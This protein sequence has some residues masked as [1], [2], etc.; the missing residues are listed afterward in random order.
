MRGM[1]RMPERLKELPA[2]FYLSPE[3]RNDTRGL[4]ET[5]FSEDSRK[6][7]DF[8]YTYK[9]RDNEILALEQDGQIVSMLHLNPYRMIVN[10]YET[11][12]NYIVAVATRE[13][14]RHR[15]CMRMLLKKAL[16]DMAAQGM[17]FAFL[18]PASERIY[19][20]F[21]FVWIGAYTE[22]PERVRRMDADD[23]NRYLAARYQ[24]FCK[25][26]ARYM[27]N[28]QAE[29]AA[30][31][32]ETWDGA[33]PPYMARITDVCGMLRLAGSSRD[34]RRYLHIRDDLIPQNHGYFLWETSGGEQRA[35]RLEERP[36]QL[37]LDLT[38]G[39]L[40]S[41]IFGSFRICL[42]ETV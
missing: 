34:R 18:M 2:P 11:K 25:R 39:E 42:S 36:G 6:F 30:E 32:G 12:S 21:D 38:V 19:S 3:R 14:Y 22:L 35:E 40:A 13:D 5:V 41:M 23:Q 17:P 27:E 28:G 37:D 4:Y 9:T 1:R 31:E 8:Y 33:V 29:R 20:P 24:M 26:D 15:S 7:V 16:R 10:G